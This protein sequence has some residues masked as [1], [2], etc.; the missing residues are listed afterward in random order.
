[1][2]KV[3]EFMPNEEQLYDIGHKSTT[4]HN[5]ITSQQPKRE[6]PN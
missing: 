3:T 5:A 4:L 1:V 6:E 2:S